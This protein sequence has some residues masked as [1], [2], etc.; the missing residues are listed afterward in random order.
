[1]EGFGLGACIY[2][3]IE[4]PHVGGHPLAAGGSRGPSM[5]GEPC[6]VQPAAGRLHSA[7]HRRVTETSAAGSPTHRKRLMSCQRWCPLRGQTLPAQ[8]RGAASVGAEESGA[9][10]VSK[11]HGVTRRPRQSTHFLPGLRDPRTPGPH[12]PKRF[13][14]YGLRLSMN[15]ASIHQIVGLPMPGVLDAWSISR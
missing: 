4:R 2:E 13:F 12:A 7:R 15:P 5:Q 10:G 9:G 8:R 14:P 11:R 1:M 3:S 6:P